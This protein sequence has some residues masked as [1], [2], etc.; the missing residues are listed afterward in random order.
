MPLISDDED[1]ERLVLSELLDYCESIA[2][3]NF[4]HQFMWAGECL[5]I[6]LAKFDLAKDT[7][8]G[9]SR[10]LTGD[11][12]ET[13][14]WSTDLGHLPSLED[15]IA[16]CLSM[17]NQ[18]DRTPQTSNN[19]KMQASLSGNSIAP[20][21]KLELIDSHGFWTKTALLIQLRSGFLRAFCDEGCPETDPSP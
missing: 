11:V 20:L 12:R 3:T 6:R 1:V 13:Y 8:V 15:P 7:G 19:W 21:R 2:G 17:A 18:Y 5:T 14:L 9:F 10:Y 16:V 4:D